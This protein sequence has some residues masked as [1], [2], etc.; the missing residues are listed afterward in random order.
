MPHL[1]RYDDR[2][3]DEE[4]Y[5]NMSIGDRLA[6]EAELRQRD[7]EL[8]ILRR[9]DRELFYDREDDE[10]PRN[11][12]R[13]AEKAAAGEPEDQVY[14]YLLIKTDVPSSHLIYS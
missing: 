4:E 9:D 10:D 3:L 13:R 11:K 6:A 7:R 14:I 1:D 12:R 5:D 2:I 8:G